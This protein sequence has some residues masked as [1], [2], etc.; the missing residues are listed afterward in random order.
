M[1]WVLDIKER[2]GWKKNIWVYCSDSNLGPFWFYFWMLS[3]MTR[4]TLRKMSNA[5]K[6]VASERKRNNL[7][8]LRPFKPRTF[9]HFAVA[10]SLPQ[11]K[12][13]NLVHTRQTPSSCTNRECRTSCTKLNFVEFRASRP[14]LYQHCTFIG[15]KRP[16]PARIESAERLARKEIL[17]SLELVV[18][19]CTCMFLRFPMESG[20]GWF[21]VC[22]I[23]WQNT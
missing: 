2:K 4:P 18:Q 20:V 9:F 1:I 23:S 13:E 11:I 15:D 6:F 16:H 21:V 7:N 17:L 3:F 19:Y 5:A 14:V 10:C 12:R 22:L 8:P